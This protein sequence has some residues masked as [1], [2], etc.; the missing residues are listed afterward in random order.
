MGWFRPEPSWVYGLINAVA[1]LI[2][3]CS[4]ALGLV[5][6][7]SIMV[8]TGKAATQGVM[9]RDAAAIENFG[10]V[11][12]LIVHKT[13]TL[14]EG[15]PRFDRA[16]PATGFAQAEVPRLA[17]S[18]DQGS[19]HPLADAIVSAA[20]ARRVLAH[21]WRW[22]PRRTSSCWIPSTANAS[23]IRRRRPCMPRCAAR[24]AT[25]TQCAPCTVCWLPTAVRAKAAINSS[26]RP[27]PSPSCWPS[28]PARSGRGTSPNSRDRP[29]GR[30]STSR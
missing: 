24:A 15:K 6:P 19:E 3:A 22:T 13:G 5:T 27:T 2:I 26:T 1:V 8:A 16:V 10:K 9:F 12:T 4:C 29:S 14:T 23:P 28:R 25:W 21:P 18:L 20:R 17:T 7:M 11:Y 30:A